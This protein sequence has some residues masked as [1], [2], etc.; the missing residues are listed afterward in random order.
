MAR[1]SRCPQMNPISLNYLMSQ[2]VREFS[3]SDWAKEWS[4]VVEV[5]DR[6]GNA[7]RMPGNPW[8]FS[9]SAGCYSAASIRSALTT[10]WG[11]DQSNA[12]AFYN[13]SLKMP[14]VG[15]HAAVLPLLNGVACATD[16]PAW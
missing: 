16:A 8:R 2:T 10:E 4:A 7:A 1:Q 12:G 11:L 5:D 15:E 9:S 14:F 6:S 13:E 3:E